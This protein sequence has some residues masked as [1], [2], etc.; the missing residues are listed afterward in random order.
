MGM[1]RVRAA[2]E[3]RG[4]FCEDTGLRDGLGRGPQNDVPA[5]ARTTDPLGLWRGRRRPSQRQPARLLAQ[6]ERRCAHR[7]HGGARHAPL[8]APRLLQLHSRTQSDDAVDF[9]GVSEAVAHDA[10]LVLSA[11]TLSGWVK[12]GSL[13]DPGDNAMAILTKNNAV[14]TARD[15]V[16]YVP[17]G[18]KLPACAS[19]TMRSRRSS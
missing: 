4:D 19:A 5:V 6:P 2:A 8:P 13:P 7:H 1:P 18:T 17:S 11:F 9:G 15:W 12:F 3:L 16:L 14:V 10:G